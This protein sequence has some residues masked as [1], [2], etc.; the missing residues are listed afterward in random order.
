M[1]PSYHLAMF[2]VE[3]APARSNRSFDT[4][5][6]VLPCASRSPVNSNVKRPHFLMRITIDSLDPNDEKRIGF[7]PMPSYAVSFS[8][9]LISGTARFVPASEAPMLCVGEV[10][11]VEVSQER[12]SEFEVLQNRATLEPLA[13]RPEANGF[14]V[15]GVVSSVQ[16]V[17]EPSGQQCIVVVAGE[18]QF[19]LSRTEIGDIDLSVGNAVRFIA[20]DVSLWD[21]AI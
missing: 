5:A 4:D 2:G 14:I 1:K 12:I 13:M 9:S 11:D 20:H 7:T 15:H 21:E 16:P 18:A 17:N 3:A 10:F 6:Q 8:G 19:F